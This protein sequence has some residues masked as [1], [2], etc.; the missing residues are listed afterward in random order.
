MIPPRP[1]DPVELTTRDLSVRMQPSPEAAVSID[2]IVGVTVH[3]QRCDLSRCLR[4]V[5]EQDLAPR[6][7]GVLLLFDGL[8]SSYEPPTV[9]A[10]LSGRTW[11]VTAH[12]GSAARARNACLSFVD[13]WL[14]RCR[15]VARLD[16]DDRFASSGSLSAAVELAER[17]QSLF[18]LGGNRVYGRDGRFLRENRAGD[19]L[20]DPLLVQELLDRMASGVA[21]N[22]LPSCNLLLAAHRGIRYPDMTGA[23]DHRLVASLLM[24][25][26][27]AA[28]IL[29][30]PLFC[31][32]T[33]DG[34][35]TRL[36]KDENRHLRARQDLAA[37]AHT[38][39]R[40]KGLP[41]RVLGWGCEGIVRLHDGLVHKH[42]YPGALTDEHARWLDGALRNSVIL[43]RARLACEDRAG[44]WVASYE[45]EPTLPANVIDRRA[46]DEFL[47]AC[48]RE[49]VV[50]GNISRSNLRQRGDGR[51]VCI[52]IG[53][54]VRPMDVSILR[55]SAARLFGISALG[56]A[57]DE[58]LRRRADH[59]RPEIWSRLGGFA[60]FYGTVVAGHLAPNVS[61]PSETHR[62]PR[63]SEVSLLIKAC[64]MDARDARSQITHIVEQ[65]VGPWDFAERIL[66]VD[67]HPGPFV[68]AHGGADRG[69]LS[70]LAAELQAR[71]VLDRV[72]VAPTEPHHVRRTNQDWFGLECSATHSSLG[73]PV[74]PHLWGFD[75]VR[76]RYVLQCDIDVL[77]GRR[78]LEHDYLAEMLEA[79][80]RE[81]VVSVG[82]NIAR[83]PG[84][85]P[86]PYDA[87]V[88]EY[89]PEVRC[90]LLDLDRLRAQRPL[91]ASLV[92]ERLAWNWYHALHEA[93]RQR[94]LRSL[95]GG[96][97]DSF[98]VHPT[99]DRKG[100]QEFLDRVR[101]LTAQGHVPTAQWERWDLAGGQGDWT[102]RRRAEPI[103]V[104]AKGRN[105]GGDRLRRFARG[106]AAQDDPGFGVIVID[107]ASDDGGGQVVRR[108][109]DWLGDRLTLV[110]HATPRGRMFNNVLAIREL[111]TNP[112]TMVVIVDLDDALA[113]R[114]VLSRVRVLA[115]A[116]HDVVLAAPFR[117]DSPTK[118]HKPNVEAPRESFGGDVWIHMR[119]FKKRLFDLIPDDAL[120]L[121]GYWVEHCEDYATM[122]PIVE[123]S[124]RP[125]YVPEYMYLHERGTVLDNEGRR[126]HEVTIER[127]LAKPSL[128]RPEGG[129]VAHRK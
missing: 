31:D 33:L 70:A 102:Y 42:F 35:A 56:F 58:L 23:E 24:F 76:T 14:S 16:W 120:Q 112:D 17:R 96:R 127:L 65:L 12:C 47:R 9:P 30:D 37:A 3:G 49:R 44:A 75:Q 109:L 68:R 55:D 39:A 7:V 73:V 89:K 117:P 72:I 107:D 51:L 1:R 108:S 82:F 2:V 53:Q 81:G 79:C 118:I 122:I 106:L 21:E 8:P 57:D 88:G 124:A 40:V 104:L 11:V 25:H 32:Y 105:T 4:S 52:D 85:A 100:D 121:D 87:E 119:A 101:D 63:H 61:I 26:G 15:W 22:E 41:G 74:T 114:G 45:H 115:A 86:R 95:R 129:R 91:P 123:L 99:N 92:A 38:W 64:A 54:W 128:R 90:G 110:R 48:L 29:K 93:Q 67:P 77:I 46:A 19:H 28:A 62:H 66:L 83:A 36:E 5:A 97:P 78:R 10:E 59:S 18:V 34:Q 60:E 13:E 80:G 125:T 27:D 116:G 6:R 98:Y 43:P 126:Q 84:S 113:D 69:S 20:L 71:G 103:V 94:G 111:C 50:V